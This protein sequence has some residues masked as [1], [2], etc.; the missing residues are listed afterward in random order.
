MWP[1]W[2]IQVTIVEVD[3]IIRI[4]RHWYRGVI[5]FLTTIA[6]RDALTPFSNS[7]CK[8]PSYERTI[9]IEFDN[10]NLMNI[11]RP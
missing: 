5:N 3:T 1:L 7:A 9:C 6:A 4:L 10:I 11:G 8:S 2:I